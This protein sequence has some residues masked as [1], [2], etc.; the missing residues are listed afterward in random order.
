MAE[1]LRQ[2]IFTVAGRFCGQVAAWDVFNEAVESNGQ[3]RES[4]W[5]ETLGPEYIE[6]AFRWAHEAAP[7]TQLFYNNYRGAG[8]GEKSDAIYAL[9]RDLVQRDVPISGVGF[10]MH[11]HSRCPQP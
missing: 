1:V 10:Q 7:D 3:L 4:I 6:R 9:V 5:L 2:H 11:Q 8:I